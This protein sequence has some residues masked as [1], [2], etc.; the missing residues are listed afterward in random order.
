MA[1]DETT[2]ETRSETSIYDQQQPA[3]ETTTCLDIAWSAVRRP[4]HFLPGVN[5]LE[6][7]AI[8]S[9]LAR[10]VLHLKRQTQPNPTPS[11]P[12]TTAAAASQPNNNPSS[13]QQ[14]QFNT[15]SHDELLTMTHTEFRDFLVAVKAGFDGFPHLWQRFSQLARD[16][17][18]SH[19]GGPP[20][21]PSPA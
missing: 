6:F 3:L 2:T 13:S 14:P 15:A 11:A 21:K 7:A 9:P 5:P 18:L 12:A 20:P 19:S 10:A 16:F 1:I 17:M 4:F 8:F